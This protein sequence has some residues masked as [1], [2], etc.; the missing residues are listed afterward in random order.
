MLIRLAL[1]EGSLGDFLTAGIAAG[2]AGAL[3][4]VQRLPEAAC[5]PALLSGAADAALVPAPW[6]LA[7]HD[8]LALYPHV[9]CSCW[10][11]GPGRIVLPGGWQEPLRPA[12]AG[13]TGETLRWAAGLVLKEQ[14]GH[15]A[16]LEEDAAPGPAVA[17]DV[18]GEWSELTG[19]PLALG[20]FAAPRA[21]ASEAAARVLRDAVLGAEQRREAWAAA[22]EQDPAAAFVADELRL[23]WDDVVTASLT[24]M[25]QYLFF[26]ETLDEVPEPVIVPLPDDDAPRP[27]L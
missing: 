21:A 16:P 22:A 15:T 9:A 8:A 23:H 18:A 14:Y 1:P 5:G 12:L 20:L 13:E 11:Y 25:K 3:F 27:I 2:S 26:Y 19:Y 6:A 4:Q 24:E 7:H 10:T 17:L